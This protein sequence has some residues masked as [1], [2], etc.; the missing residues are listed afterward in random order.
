[1]LL[2][3]KLNVTSRKSNP[4]G[5]PLPPVLS[6]RV[7]FA[8]HGLPW[9]V[10]STTTRRQ[11]CRTFRSW[12]IGSLSDNSIQIITVGNLADP[13]RVFLSTTPLALSSFRVSWVL[14]PRRQFLWYMSLITSLAL[15]I[16]SRKC[17]VLR[18]FLGFFLPSSSQCPSIF[19]WSAC[20]AIIAA[21]PWLH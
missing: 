15:Q 8:F 19:Q 6:T 9:L 3:Q 17:A 20:W 21:Q 13:I 12:S 10:L 18:N 2:V 4:K 5:L 1:M 14:W 11:Q 7:V 16:S